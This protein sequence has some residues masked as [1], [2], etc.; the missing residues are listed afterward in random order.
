MKR[1]QRP[2][3]NRFKTMRVEKKEV[4]PQEVVVESYCLCD[5]CG[6]RIKKEHYY[7]AFDFD[8]EIKTGRVFEDGSGSGEI[9]ALDLCSTCS[10]KAVQLLTEN[11][12]RVQRNEWSF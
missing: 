9:W 2:R 5:K 12:F 11:G 3:K 1:A 10:D 6:E 8:F 7:D 4:R